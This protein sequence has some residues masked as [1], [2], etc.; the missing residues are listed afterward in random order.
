RAVL[1][2]VD[3]AKRR[4]TAHDPAGTPGFTA[5]ENFVGG[6]EGPPSDVYGLAATA[7]TLLTGTAP[8]GEGSI[9]GILARQQN[10]GPTPPTK[11]R[12]GLPAAVETVLTRALQPDPSVRYVTASEFACAFSISL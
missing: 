2:D 3:I 4:G 7:Y 10:E 9:D 6:A 8:F 5:P 12:P 11:W 1:I